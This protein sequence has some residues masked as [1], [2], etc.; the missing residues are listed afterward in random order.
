[1]SCSPRAGSESAS[2][3]IAPI[4]GRARVAIESDTTLATQLNG[5]G[6]YAIYPCLNGL[7]D[8]ASPIIL[9]GKHIANVFIGQFLTRA[10]DESYFLK[11]AE[12]CGFDGA[13]YLA[14]LRE[15]PV[16]EEQDIP[17]ILDLLARMTRVITALSADRKRAIDEHARQS[18]ILD[19]I[20][21]AVFWKDL[22]GRYLG[23]NAAFARAAGAQSPRDIVA[24][25]DFDLH[26]PRADIEAYVADDRAIIAT[27]TPRLHYIEDV[28]L[29]DGSRR[30]IETSKVPLSQDGG[31]P[32]GVVGIFEDVTERERAAAIQRETEEKFRLAFTTGLDAMYWATLREGLIIEVNASFEKVFGYSREEAVGKTSLGLGLYGNPDDRAKM[33]AA[34]VA[35]GFV[36]DLELE[37]IKRGGESIVISLSVS[38]VTVGTQDFILGVI[39]D[40][41]AQRRAEAE[42]ER[43]RL[44]LQQAQKMESV[45][46]LAGGVAHDFNN[47]LTVIGANADF[48]LQGLA[49]DDPSVLDIREIL[50][51]TQRAAGL[52]RQ[53]LAF[54][55]KQV[56]DMKVMDVSELAGHTAKM[57]KRL[58]G[59]DIKLE[60]R[61]AAQPCLARVDEGQ[62]DQVL[63]NLAVN[64]RDAMPKGGTLTLETARVTGGGTLAVTYPRLAGV[65]LIQLT[66]RDTGCGMNE[67]VKARAFEPFFTT[68]AEGKG[69]GLGLSM[70]YGIIKQ[71]GGE[72]D[73]WSEPDC[74]TEFRM[75]LPQAQAEAD[76]LGEGGDNAAPY[77]GSE[78]ILLVEDEDAIRRIIKRAMTDQGY[79]VLD[80]ANGQAALKLMADRA[81]AVDLLLT[82]VV[83]P[84][85]SGRDLAQDLSGRNLSRRTLYMSGYTDDAIVQHGILEPGLALLTKPFSQESLARKVRDVLDGPVH[86][87]RP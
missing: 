26:W 14:A 15:V 57:L 7:T 48:V 4:R 68:K 8:C 86:K 82:D 20:P 25:T 40:I 79:E 50:A 69:T 12:A 54:S 80:A 56:M 32:Y 61:F 31:A 10:P 17:Q 58:I 30:R 52:T 45:G 67:Q 18:I 73:I 71:S 33:V 9:E 51:A 39:K 41:T 27:N 42:R 66:V 29:V 46:R 1:M 49:P 64:A 74:G 60:T 47:L 75:Y 16:V 77:R 43:L 62:I 59:E 11:Q 28:Q 87:A 22:G 72:I 35:N 65:A 36:R 63:M 21:Q 38:Q 37:G 34:V 76:L 55:R 70:I 78:T 23:C 13:D 44:E 6:Q 5:G 85:I 3:I 19:T 81:A 84:G 2:S 24:K 53:L 83:M